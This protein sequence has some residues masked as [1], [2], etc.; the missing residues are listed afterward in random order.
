LLVKRGLYIF[1]FV[2]MLIAI[3]LYSQNVTI[4]D[5]GVNGNSRIS[6]DLI[7]ATAGLRIGDAFQ[8]ESVSTAIKSLYKLNVFDDVN[9]Q[10]TDLPNGIRLTISVIELPVI[11]KLAYDGN[12][13]LSDSKIEE[14]SIIKV[15]T[16]WSGVVQAENT[17][18]ILAEYKAKGYNT[19]AIN[20]RERETAD[21]IDLQIDIV[22][23][24]KIVVRRIN[25]FGNK[26]IDNKQLLKQ[27]KTK[28]KSLFRSGT[29]EQEKY[30]EDL[31]AIIDYYQKEGYIDARVVRFDDSME[32]DRFL[33][34]NIYL[35]EGGQF[36][37]GSVSVSGNSHFDSSAILAKFTLIENEVFNMENFN[38]QLAAVSSMYYEE[39]YLYYRSD[40]QIRKDGNIVNIHVEITENTR[41][42]IH[43]VHITGNSRTK[44]K[45]IRRQLSVAP[46]DY[47]RYSRVIRSQQNV[48]NLGF[49][50]PDLGIDYVP[51]N[52]EGDVDLYLNVTDRSSGT[53][54]GGIGY[55]SR[56]S[57]VGNFG[58]SHNNV[59]GNNWRT[60]LAW[61]FSKVSNNIDFSFTNP[62][63][64]DTDLLFGFNLYHVTRE[65]NAQ[66]YKIA[67]E[68]GGLWLGYPIKLLDYTQI[69]GTYKHYYKQY[70]IIN[71]GRESTE[72]IKLLDAEGRQ[73]TR[74]FSLTLVRDSR[75]NIF[76]PTSGS[77]LR[78]TGE[79]AGGPLG[80]DFDFYKQTTEAS[81]FTPLFWEAVLRT[82]WRVGFV[83]KYGSRGS[84]VPPDERFYLGGTGD[85]GIR[86]YGEREI[87]PIDRRHNEYG[88][89]RS[90]LFSTEIGV[91]IATDQFIGLLFLDS[92]NSYFK[93]SDIDVKDFYTG[94]GA[95]VRI[96]TPMGLIGFD[97][98]YSFKT[99][100]W[101]PHFQ[102]GTT[103]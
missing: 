99:D 75:D 63:L 49:F 31:K 50:E 80:G 89:L 34:L 102:F 98:A 97:Y 41:A 100:K 8:T 70:S 52:S 48:Y 1:L 12:K 87:Y 59:F 94:S 38:K 73:N 4:L 54:N 22:E 35:E 27:M 66:N 26:Q 36:F 77:R 9:V 88:G 56:D 45:V 64:Y 39:G 69:T 14:L 51:I 81:W 78:V 11:A 82:K 18:R 23:G 40:P 43:K 17:K 101:M 93:F 24:K 103:F 65:W 53:I 71:R 86:G 96:R 33:I 74:S 47:F 6:T 91:P 84:V 5:V 85:D 19:A 32:E 60:S 42:K 79:I 3:P 29:F 7:L 10:A 25:F 15:G 72:T 20:Y 37:F 61:E 62:Y 21:G 95:G 2:V 68:G 58:I 30:Q 16:Y 90:V 83:D 57:V 28:Q 44:E 76:F 92:G 13:A 55:N 67:N 46:G